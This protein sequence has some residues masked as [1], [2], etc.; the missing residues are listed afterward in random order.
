MSRRQEVP[1]VDFVP[2]SKLPAFI[3]STTNRAPRE[4]ALLALI[5]GDAS[6]DEVVAALKS[7][8]QA[9]DPKMPEPRSL[10]ARPIN[11]RI[12]YS[13]LACTSVRV[14]RQL[15]KHSAIQSTLAYI[16]PSIYGSARSVEGLHFSAASMGQ[17]PATPF[18]LN[19]ADDYRADV[20]SAITTLCEIADRNG[21]HYCHWFF[22]LALLA[23][24]QYHIFEAVATTRD[25]F[26]NLAC[27][28]SRDGSELLATRLGLTRPVQV[29]LRLVQLRNLEVF[30]VP[31]I[32][33][34]F[35]ILGVAFC[36][37]RLA[38]EERAQF[39][40][41][42]KVTSE[43]RLQ[44]GVSEVECAILNP[45]GDVVTIVIGKGLVEYTVLTWL[46]ALQQL[47]S[48]PNAVVPCG[49]GGLPRDVPLNP[50]SRALAKLD[51][52]FAVIAIARSYF[53][54]GFMPAWLASMGIGR[55]LG[56]FA[57]EY[58]ASLRTN[59]VIES[60]VVMFPGTA[61][62]Q[63]PASV[64]IKIRHDE[65]VIEDAWESFDLHIPPLG[66]AFPGTFYPYTG[67][68][69]RREGAKLVPVERDSE[70][71]SLS[72]R[73]RDQDDDSR[74]LLRD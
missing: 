23:L 48:R 5:S 71:G 58:V 60:E 53:E 35:G 11:A 61:W 7:I 10:E 56:A 13:S 30:E 29:V 39:L 42:A 19:K 70:V 62:E 54:T 32:A 20:V 38:P 49:Y 26:I 69:V 4:T 50:P 2:T 63:S 31:N 55:S 68:N 22:A 16:A 27:G 12:T 28:L 46:R 8:A 59:H 25:E 3:S 57:A 74:D 37:F 14:M 64:L 65:E 51:P 41:L 66:S 24:D 17:Y 36:Q 6:T 40:A 21:I 33:F 44:V 72:G 9:E 47:A 73:D 1:L 43:V 45:I 67:P 15:I 34:P 52:R 18:V